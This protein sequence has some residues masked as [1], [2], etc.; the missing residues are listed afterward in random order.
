MHAAAGSYAKFYKSNFIQSE[1][2]NGALFYADS[3]S[4]M[5]FDS[6]TFNQIGGKGIKVIDSDL[7]IA[8]DQFYD[9]SDSFIWAERSNVTMT[10]ATL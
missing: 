3:Y 8:D 2:V 5:E 6:N 4:T 1:S 7:V 9:G 10:G